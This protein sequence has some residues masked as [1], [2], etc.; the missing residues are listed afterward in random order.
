MKK[1]WVCAGATLAFWALIFLGPAIIMLF[2]NIG[3]YFSGGG[4]GPESFMY[5]VLQFFSQPTACVIAAGAA[6]AI[7]DGKHKVCTIANCVI[8]ALMCFLF[9]MVAGDKAQL[10]TMIISAVVMSVMA[11]LGFVKKNSKT[12][13]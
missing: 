8:A 1:F 9:A 10:A 6:E 13:T 2:N 12:D 4:Y 11:V 7:C 5:K 3:Y